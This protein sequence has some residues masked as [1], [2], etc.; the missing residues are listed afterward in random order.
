MAKDP[1]FLFY[2]KDWI[3]GT[4]E[5]LPDEKGVYIDLLCYQHQRG[6]LPND[7]K[8]LARMVGISVDEFEKIWSV[9]GCKFE[10]NGERTLNRKLSEV[11]GERRDKGHRNKIIGMF[12]SLCRKSDLSQLHLKQIRSEFKVSDFE[13]LESERISERLSEWFMER[14]ALLGNGNGN[15]DANANGD[16]NGIRNGAEKKFFDNDKLNDVF[17]RW[18]KMLHERGKPMTQSS[19]EQLQMK[20]N[21][22]QDDVSIK[23]IEQSLENGWLTLRPVESTDQPKPEPKKYRMPI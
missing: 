10:A 22:Q 7:T 11:M 12:G 9:I 19:I 4:A 20:M 16:V 14:L 3:E 17:C 13:H 2:S 23:Q 6:D 21:Y 5:L 15:G 18:L 8:R 1:A